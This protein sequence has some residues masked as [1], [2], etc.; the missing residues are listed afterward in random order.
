MEESQA[1]TRDKVRINHL[2]R[3]SLAISSYYA[4]YSR[5]PSPESGCLPKSKLES[6]LELPVDP[7]GRTTRRCTGRNGM[8]YEYGV[9]K[10]QEQEWFYVLAK[11]ESSALSNID[12]LPIRINHAVISNIKTDQ[13][14]SGYYIIVR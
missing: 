4:D 14:K 5:Y 8:T 11:L 9:Y 10:Y 13:G 2:Q 6:Y 7:L 1:L 12:K 3:V